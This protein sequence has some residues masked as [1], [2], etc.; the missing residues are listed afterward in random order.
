MF[1]AGV[2][3]Q[4]RLQSTC[5]KFL[6]GK[7]FVTAKQSIRYAMDISGSFDGCKESERKTDHSLQRLKRR[8][9]T[10]PLSYTI[11]RSDGKLITQR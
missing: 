7:K 4:I 3:T 11:S 6:I 1:R 5:L 2:E 9:P 10:L 8:G